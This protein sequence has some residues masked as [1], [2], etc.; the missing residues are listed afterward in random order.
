MNELN[1]FI[2]IAES[3]KELKGGVKEKD[4]IKKLNEDTIQLALS[5]VKV[6]DTYVITTEK[7]PYKPAK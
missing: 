7:Y 5:A 4:N 3:T 6:P 2:F 1:I